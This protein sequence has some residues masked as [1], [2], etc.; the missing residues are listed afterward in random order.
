MTALRWAAIA[1]ALLAA[2]RAAAVSCSAGVPPLNFGM[3]DVFAPAPLQ[4][5]TTL[6][7]T[8]SKTAGDPASNIRVNYTLSLTT[9]SSNTYA[10]R[11]LASGASRLGYNLYTNAARTSVWGDGTGGSATVAGAFTLSTGHP[12]ESAAHPIYGSI[13]AGADASV[14]AYSDGITVTVSY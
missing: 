8:C 7:V 5:A 13:P 2:D 4:S 10:Q 11:T 1:I 9:G 6:S 12:S 14:G 3:Y